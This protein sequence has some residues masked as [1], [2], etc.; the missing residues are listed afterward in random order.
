MKSTYK[1]LYKTKYEYK[2]EVIVQEIVQIEE[3]I[4]FSK[5]NALNTN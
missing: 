4:Y 2:K 5:L 3:H 1:I